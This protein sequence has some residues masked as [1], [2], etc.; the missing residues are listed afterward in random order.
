ML[1]AG[2]LALAAADAVGGFAPAV[3]GA[4]IGFFG[5]IGVVLA[6]LLVGRRE[7][8]GDEDL[9]GAALH[10]VAAAG[11][12][13]GRRVGQDLLCLG[14]HCP[15]G[16]VH[17]GKG[18][19]G[20]KVVLHLGG[21]GHAGQHRQHA[22]QAGGEPQ[23]PGR[24]RRA[25][26]GGV[27]QGFHLLRRVGQGPSLDRLHDDD[28]FAVAAGDLIVFPRGHLGVLPVGIV[29][30]Q[31]DDVHA[32]VLGQQTVQQGRG[33]VERKAVVA[34]AARGLLLLDKVPQ[35]PLGVVPGVGVLHGVEQVV[36]EIA[37]AGAG[38]ALLQLAV[39]GLDVLRDAGVQLGGKGI[40]FPR[41]A[42]DQG[43]A[44]G[45]LAAVV[46]IG[47]VK[48]GKTR[49]HK[50]VHHPAG[51]GNVDR[52]P[53]LRQAHQAKAQG[54]VLGGCTHFS[55]PFRIPFLRRGP[56]KKLFITLNFIALRRYGFLQSKFSIMQKRKTKERYSFLFFFLDFSF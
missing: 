35:T 5:L 29:D 56:D 11:A 55:H 2:P 6:Q 18:G 44:G 50:G 23:R 47:G 52:L 42:L 51:L 22:V 1:G 36:V 26:P 27:E 30:L 17:G 7:H 24:V 43:F 10:A 45:L 53:R 9:P 14:D 38:Q 8:L 15:V 19:K 32:G 34:D 12:G 13:D 49:R 3:D 4:G 46:D 39:G 28:L 37:C 25:G 41:V 21:V 54:G 33:A 40:A 48:I 16:L 20:R 31:L